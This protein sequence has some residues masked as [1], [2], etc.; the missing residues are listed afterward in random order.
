MSIWVM[1]SDTPPQSLAPVLLMR[2]SGQTLAM[3]QRDVVEVLPLP[4]LAPLPEAPPIVLGAFH[5]GGE[6]VLVLQ[7]AALLGLHGPAEGNPLYHHLLLLPEQPGHPRLA[8]RVDRATDILAADA[9]LLP[10]GESFNDCIEGDIRL[11]GLLVPMLTAERLLTAHE[12]ARL[13]AFAAR[14]AARDAAL[15][16]PATAAA[17][18]A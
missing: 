13:A 4:R 1:P 14:S 2:V 12:A 9:T 11:D 8:L 3:R 17:G 16:P 10:P 5:L 6:I 7:M 18:A 15:A